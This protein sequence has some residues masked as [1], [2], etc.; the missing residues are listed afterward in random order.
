MFTERKAI[1]NLGLD[2]NQSY[3]AEEIKSAYRRLAKIHHPDVDGDPEMMMALTQSYNEVRSGYVART[4]GGPVNANYSDAWKDLRDA[5]RR[6]GVGVGRQRCHSDEELEEFF[7][8]FK[9]KKSESVFQSEVVAAVKKVGGIAFNVHGHGMQA[10]GWPDLYIAHRQWTG[11]LEL[12]VREGRASVLQMKR[13]DD[14]RKR[15]VDAFYLRYVDGDA[16][17]EV[18][19]SSS[20]VVR[21]TWGRGFTGQTRSDHT[22]GCDRPESPDGGCVGVTGV[23]ARAVTTVCHTSERAIRDV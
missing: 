7:N 22:P 4:K 19:H 20:V 2:P 12:K 13:V 16:F 21:F 1:E 14:L 17:M 3:G 8:K 11:W 23:T 18:G 10:A 6:G 9:P 15:D 5:V